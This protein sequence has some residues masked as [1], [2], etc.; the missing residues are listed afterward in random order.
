MMIYMVP[1]CR[2]EAYLT[3]LHLFPLPSKARP[4]RRRRLLRRRTILAMTDK[5]LQGHSTIT[6]DT[7][8]ILYIDDNSASYIITNELSLFVGNLTSVN[9]KVDTIKATQMRQRYEGT[10]RLELVDDSN[11]AH[12]Y[13]IPGAIY[14]SSSQFNLLGIPKLADFFKDRNYLQVDDVDSSGTTVKSSGCGSR[15]MWDHGKH[16]RNFTHGDSTLPEIM[17]YQ[18]HGYFDVFCTRLR[19]CYQDGVA[20]AFSSAFSIL[21]SYVDSA[22]IG[23]DGEDSDEEDAVPTEED[24]DWFLPPPPPSAPMPP[25]SLPAIPSLINTFKSGMSLSF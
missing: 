1:L 16:T 17:L 11:V 24:V 15:L 2:G 19:R 10:I 23:L 9:V 21:P 3:Y 12:T 20:F 14:D 6:F 25:P 8:G 4:H 7:D 13:E 18:G 22:A 5:T